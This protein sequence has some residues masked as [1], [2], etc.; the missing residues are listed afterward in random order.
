[1]GAPDK[2]KS[3]TSCHSN[4]KHPTVPTSSMLLCDCAPSSF[5]SIIAEHHKTCAASG[6]VVGDCIAARARESKGI[7]S[8]STSRTAASV[9]IQIFVHAPCSQSFSKARSGAYEQRPRGHE[10]LPTP[11]HLGVPLVAATELSTPAKPE[12]AAPTPRTM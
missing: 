11:R 7:L 10:D 6:H 9:E 4:D 8:E 12:L 5:S 2:G 3:A 1:M